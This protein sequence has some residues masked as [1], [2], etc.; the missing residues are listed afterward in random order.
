[1][2]FETRKT[3]FTVFSL[4]RELYS[5]VKSVFNMKL[6]SKSA[7]MYTYENRGGELI[8]SFVQ[9]SYILRD[10]KFLALLLVLI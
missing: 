5:S 2:P 9:L 3:I 8:Y 10:S 6:E 7:Q 1:M 4:N